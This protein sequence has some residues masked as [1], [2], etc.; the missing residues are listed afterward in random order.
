MSAEQFWNEHRK[1]YAFQPFSAV[2]KFAEAYAASLLAERDRELADYKEDS[3]DTATHFVKETARLNGE[4]REMR[5]ALQA[6]HF[7]LTGLAAYLATCNTDVI[8]ENLETI[9]AALHKQADKVEA[10]IQKSEAV[11]RA[12]PQ[13]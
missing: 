1:E 7:H 9:I 2:M 11:V 5:E 6:A 8:I 13:K 4:L 10:V 12:E 3:A